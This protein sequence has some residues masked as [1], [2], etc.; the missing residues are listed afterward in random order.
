MKVTIKREGKAVNVRILILPS[1][2]ITNRQIMD[3]SVP[4]F[5]SALAMLNKGETLDN[6]HFLINGFEVNLYK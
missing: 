6:I 3:S 1:E 2:S 5:Q 4:Y